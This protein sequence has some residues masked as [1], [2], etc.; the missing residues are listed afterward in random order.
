MKNLYANAYYKSA[1]HIS[2]IYHLWFPLK[3]PNHKLI[4]CH[5]ASLFICRCFVFWNQRFLKLSH[6]IIFNCLLL[7]FNHLWKSVILT[8]VICIASTGNRTL[9]S[10]LLCIADTNKS[11]Q[12]FSYQWVAIKLSSLTMLYPNLW[13]FYLLCLLCLPLDIR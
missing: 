7:I 8:F 9:P 5:D 3:W 4:H 6:Q 13:C 1:Y 2:L 10:N 12:H 11:T